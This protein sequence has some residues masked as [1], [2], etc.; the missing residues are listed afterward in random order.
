MIKFSVGDFVVYSNG[1][2]EVDNEYG[3]TIEESFELYKALRSIF[4]K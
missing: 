3:L 4:D 2:I 1:V